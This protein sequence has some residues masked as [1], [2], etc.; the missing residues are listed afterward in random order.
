MIDDK[1]EMGELSGTQLK[2]NERLDSR[3]SSG[4]QV[5]P[6]ISHSVSVDLPALSLDE[7]SDTLSQSDVGPGEAGNLNNAESGIKHSTDVFAG[8]EIPNTPSPTGEVT[9]TDATEIRDV[10]DSKESVEV[11]AESAE[12]IKVK[13]STAAVEVNGHKEID[14]IGASAVEI[15]ER[16]G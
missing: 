12:S 10:I 1:L 3:P 14:P 2:I 6:G 13:E 16:E 8:V 15:A 9:G 4:L 11:M 5:A 7:A